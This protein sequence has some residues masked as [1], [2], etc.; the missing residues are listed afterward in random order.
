MLRVSLN[1]VG[2]SS[3]GGAILLLNAPN[4]SRAGAGVSAE[5]AVSPRSGSMLPASAVVVTV[6]IA[7]C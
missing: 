1:G 2:V 7:S 5:V 6:D 4:S 3:G